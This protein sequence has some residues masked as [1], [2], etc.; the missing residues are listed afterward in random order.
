MKFNRSLI[1]L[2]TLFVFAAC[3]KDSDDPPAPSPVTEPLTIVAAKAGDT[4][5]I[6]GEHFSEAIEKNTVQFNGVP[7]TIVVATIAELKV[8][9]PANATTGPVTVTVNGQ[10]VT[11]GTLI[12]NPFRL[13]AVKSNYQA[14]TIRQL[15][16]IDP[17]TGNETVIA[18][19]DANDDIPEDMIYL[20]ATNELIGVKNGTGLLRIN[21]ATQQ[22]ASVEVIT[23]TDMDIQELVVD[24][25]SNLYAVKRNW[26]NPNRYMYALIKIDPKTGVATVVKEFAYTPYWESLVYLTATHEVIGIANNSRGLFKLS[27]VNKDTA[28]VALHGASNL[29]YRELG[30]DNQSRLY[31]YKGDY[32][33]PNNAI[34]QIVTLNVT[35]GQETLMATT[36]EFGRL[37]DRLIFVP[38]RSELMGLSKQTSLYRLNVNTKAGSALPLTTQQ[39]ITYNELIS[40]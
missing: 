29:D 10:T 14:N 21:L 20:P 17:A 8:V 15:V 33:D 27:L 32:S 3:Q 34:G 13:Y 2:S 35:T 16:S 5:Y 31:A 24:K 7:G 9:V 38:Q 19:L 23:G 6:K 39:N 37:E 12:I 26:S 11:V 1:I 28:T 25:F 22:T 18:A 4:V 40:N 36:T 30:L